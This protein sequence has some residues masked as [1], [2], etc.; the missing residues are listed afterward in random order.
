MTPNQERF[1]QEQLS[2]E[3]LFN[4]INII[5][6]GLMGGSIAASCK[7][8]KISK[9][10]A[11]FDT[12][13][14]TTDF[15]LANNIIDELYDFGEI[16]DNDLTIIAA[17]LLGYEDIL[18]KLSLKINKGTLIDIGSLK[19]CVVSWAENILASKAANFIACHPIAGSD[20]SG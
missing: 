3:Q 14:A 9:I 17:P 1:N 16:S 5:G 6:L 11:G 2:Q 7:K 19:F 20:K 8:H 12:D 10:V 4:K 15:A 13:K 18:K